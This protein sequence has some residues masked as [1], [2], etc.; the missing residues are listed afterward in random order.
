[1]P[2]VVPFTKQQQEELE[3]LGFIN[4]KAFVSPMSYDFIIE[5]YT[6]M[7][8]TITKYMPGK[9]PKGRQD[10]EYT[11]SVFNVLDLLGEEFQVFEYSTYDFKFGLR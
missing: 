3:S 6:L 11:L 4:N 7:R 5:G 1:M 8:F 10:E 9:T 2:I